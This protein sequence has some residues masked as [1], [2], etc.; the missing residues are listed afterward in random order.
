MTTPQQCAVSSRRGKLISLRHPLALSFG[1][2]G[3]CVCRLPADWRA[4]F[5][6][7]DD[8]LITDNPM[9]KSSDGLYRFWFT[10]D[11]PDYYPLTSSFWWLE[12]RLWGKN[13]TGWHAVNVLLHA[14]DVVLVWMVFRHLKIP[15]AWLAALLFAVHPVNVVTVA[16][17]SE[18]KNTLSMLFFAVAI[19]LY[20][21]F[22]E[23]TTDGVTA[24]RWRHFCWPCSAKR[25]W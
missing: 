19:L 3:P 9:V 5:V 7:D 11:A 15:G 17:I 20:L 12:W 1:L 21:R 18:Q 24:F 2:G 25:R 6:W 4:G 10:T 16:W 8:P 22:D 14:A 13:A 23:T